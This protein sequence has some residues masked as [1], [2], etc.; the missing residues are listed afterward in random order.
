MRGY[1]SIVASA[2]ILLL[3]LP[4][5]A[6]NAGEILGQ[7]TWADGNGHEYV[8]VR[9]EN[10]TWDESMEDLN[11]LVPGFHLATITSQEENDFIFN[12]SCVPGRGIG[13]GP[14]PRAGV[15]R[16][17]PSRRERWSA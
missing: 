9:V 11:V 10:A 5:E 2:V 4:P 1:L 3:M 17:L 16:E 14:L 7:R 6:S 8:L 15:Q 12:N 13:D